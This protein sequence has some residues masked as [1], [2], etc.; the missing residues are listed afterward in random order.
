MSCEMCP[1]KGQKIVPPYAAPG[2]R[3]MLV[4]EAPGEQE[5][6]A[7]KPFIGAAG[8]F[9]NK[10]L[11]T[12]GLVR[13]N[14][15]VTN[16]VKCRPPGNKIAKTH[17]KCCTDRFQE[18]VKEANPE[19]ILAVGN[20]ALTALTGHSGIT[21]FRGQVLPCK[22]L[23]GAKVF[24]TLHP[25]SALYQPGNAPV[26]EQDFSSFLNLATKQWESVESEVKYTVITSQNYRVLVS[27]LS[28][29]EAIAYDVECE[30]GEGKPTLDW[31]APGARVNLLGIATRER[32][33][34]Y[35]L[36]V[37]E[38]LPILWKVIKKFFESDTLPVKIAHNSKF[39]NHWLRKYGIRPHTHFDTLIAS[40]LYDENIPHGLEYLATALLKVAPWKARAEEDPVLYNAKDVYYTMR[41]YPVLERLLEKHPRVYHLFYHLD[42]P[43]SRAVEDVEDRGIWIDTERMEK[44]FKALEEDKQNALHDLE[45][46]LPPREDPWWE[47]A[48]EPN[49]NPSKFLSKVVLEHLAMP[50]VGRTEKGAPSIGKETLAEYAGMHPFFPALIEYRKREKQLTFFRSWDELKI[51]GAD[52]WRLYPSY[53][54]AKVPKDD[55]T[56]AGT[57]TG[58]ISAENPNV[59]QVPKEGVVRSVL[60]APDG[61]KLIVADYSQIELRVAAVVFNEPTM[62]EAY[63]KGEDIH[64]LTAATVAN[65]PLAQ[66]TKEQRSKAKAVN[67]GFLYG[68]GSKT[69]KTYALVSYKIKLSAAESERARTSYFRR[70][71]RLD[72]GHRRIKKVC[73]VTGQVSTLLGRIRHL[74]DIK[75]IEWKVKAGAERKALNS[76]VQGTAGEMTKLAIVK[77][78]EIAV[79]EEFRIVTTVHDSILAEVR[80]GF[81]EKWSS[82][83]KSVMENLPLEEFGCRFPVPIVADVTT[84]KYWGE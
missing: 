46:Y 80:E 65:V 18:E 82:I 76:P 73:E 25:A 7:G 27:K 32:D 69:F 14:I 19:Y 60:G 51:Q 75:S 15:H 62:L 41:L 24:P 83:M 48:G 17:I 52:G 31:R 13:S 66:V 70:Y 61:W 6:R 64:T 39:D 57:V 44:V 45:K 16:V 28:S 38:L 63:R 55:G 42:M 21:R 22:W 47:K 59:Q 11:A 26:I 49:Y 8:Q 68:M 58:R 35:V 5:D 9:L 29:A 53:N 43:F 12:V 30:D 20:T 74:P 56:E 37:T 84:G 78:E 3:I 77:L 79:P 54:V 40:Y 81:E 72:A 33:T 2:S 4:G 1:L 34:V 67:F 23:P 10:M 71:S 50:V 36:V